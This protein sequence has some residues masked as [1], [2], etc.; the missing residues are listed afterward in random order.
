[1]K[2]KYA[3]ALLLILFLT[4]STLLV[5]CNK[6]ETKEAEEPAPASAPAPEKVYA[7]VMIDGQI[8]GKWVT[9][10]SRGDYDINGN[11][12]YSKDYRGVE[13]WNE[14]DANGNIIHSKSSDGTE[15]WYE[16]NTEGKEI[17]FKSISEQ[18]DM[19]D[20]ID[21]YFNEIITF[22]TTE[23]W[24]E[25][26]SK[27]NL[28]H[29]KSTSIKTDEVS[30]KSSDGS[31]SS[32]ED[33]WYE[34][35][36][37]GKLIHKKNSS[38]YEEWHEYD[39]RGN[40]IR[41]K[42]TSDNAHLSEI[43]YDANGN[44]T[45]DRYSSSNGIGYEMWYEFDNDGKVI[46]SKYTFDLEKWYE[47]WYEYEYN[48]AGHNVIRKNADGEIIG[49]ESYDSEERLTYEKSIETKESNVLADMYQV[50][51]DYTS[52]WFLEYDEKGNTCHDKWVDT[53]ETGETSISEYWTVYEYYPSSDQIKTKIVYNPI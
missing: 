2:K 34:Y 46:Y 3:L 6:E 43:E 50:W 47:Y 27:G 53:Y 25:Y 23:R 44:I 28:I 10:R 5:G 37:N 24:S 32:A 16:Y 15:K 49:I 41:Y 40:E 26:D 14:Y 52:E 29:S 36:S 51:E 20:V 19:N 38:G 31:G 7:Q 13:T 17:Y 42:D 12:T 8:V 22:Y 11:L 1:M 45:Y 18:M 39:A 30:D 21:K 4:I 33:I 9:E 48:D 35:D